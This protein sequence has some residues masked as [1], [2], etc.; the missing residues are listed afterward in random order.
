MMLK[1]FINDITIIDRMLCSIKTRNLYGDNSF[2]RLFSSKAKLQKDIK[3]KKN[4][5]SS[6]LSNDNK[7]TLLLKIKK[8]INSEPVKVKKNIMI[9]HLSSIKGPGEFL[10]HLRYKGRK[11]IIKLYDSHHSHHSHYHHSP[12]N[13]HHHHHHRNHQHHYDH[14]HIVIIF[15]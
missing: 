7:S 2:I 11:V 6:K 10:Y 1:R 4:T 8:N 3:S 15:I 12:H 5:T 9:Q 14:H 13:H